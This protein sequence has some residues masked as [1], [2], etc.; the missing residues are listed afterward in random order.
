MNIYL[1]MYKFSQGRK[2]ETESTESNV[3]L[4]FSPFCP[5]SVDISKNIILAH[6][7]S[8]ITRELISLPLG[9]YTCLLL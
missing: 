6:W 2:K 5:L 8:L 4:I 1:C 7:F 9:I 3:W